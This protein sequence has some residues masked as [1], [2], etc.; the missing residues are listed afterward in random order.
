[1]RAQTSK[2]SGIQVQHILKLEGKSS[3]LKEPPDLC[4]IN[5]L[6]SL[7]YVM[8]NRSEIHLKIALSKFSTRGLLCLVQGAEL[9]KKLKRKKKLS[10]Y[11]STLER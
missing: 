7:S 1:M 2:V 6:I 9:K 11:K 4:Y 5:N 8:K 3:C 10:T